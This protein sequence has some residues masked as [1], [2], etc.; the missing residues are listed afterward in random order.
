MSLLKHRASE[1]LKWIRLLFS[2]C[3]SRRRSE[4]SGSDAVWELMPYQFRIDW[5]VQQ[6]EC[7]DSRHGTPRGLINRVH[8][9]NS[10]RA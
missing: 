3:C 4:P 2:R 10:P 7:V 8:R 1:F 6:K 5:F 9:S